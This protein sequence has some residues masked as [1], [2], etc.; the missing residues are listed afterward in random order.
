[1][2]LRAS[3]TDALQQRSEHP[4][5]FE[6]FRFNSLVSGSIQHAQVP[7]KLITYNLL[8]VGGAANAY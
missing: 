2:A 5:D 1:M 8:L 7:L 6:E 3:H 4:L